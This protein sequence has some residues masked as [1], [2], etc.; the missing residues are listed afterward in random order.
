MERDIPNV[1]NLMFQ[2]LKLL[3]EQNNNL[4][5]YSAKA[6]DNHN[7]HFLVSITAIT[8]LKQTPSTN[9]K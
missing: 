1:L 5:K 4:K 9:N 3:Y 2:D 7:N 6:N 8:S